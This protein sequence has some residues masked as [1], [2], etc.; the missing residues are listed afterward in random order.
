MN[1]VDGESNDATNGACLSNVLVQYDGT[2]MDDDTTRLISTVQHYPLDEFN[3]RYLMPADI[4]AVKTLCAQ[5][6]PIEY[7]DCWYNEITSNQQLIS[8]AASTFADNRIV[9]ILVA[10][11]KTLNQCNFEDRD[12]LA[13]SFAANTRVAYILS[14]GVLPEYRRRGLAGRLLDHLL[15]YLTSTVT[16]DAKAVYLHVL[17]E[18]A[19]AIRFYERRRFRRHA[20]LVHYYRIDDVPCNGY[21]YVLYVNGGEAP[22]SLHEWCATATALLV[23][24]LRRLCH[25]LRRVLI[26]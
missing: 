12:I 8:L 6:F 7:P 23:Y 1:D 3:L 16:G 21:T 2:P 15:H 13:K 22:F 20:V 17:C 24:P 4:D 25:V 5:V 18:N 9:A 19:T 10:E 11:M 26:G 14:L